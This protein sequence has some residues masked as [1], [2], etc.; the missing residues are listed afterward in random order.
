LVERLCRR[1]WGALSGDLVT[2]KIGTIL[3][4]DSSI[5]SDEIAK[6]IADDT[7]NIITRLISLDYQGYL[8]VFL[9]FVPS[10]VLVDRMQHLIA[11][12]M[13]N[14][15]QNASSPVPPRPTLFMPRPDA[16]PLDGNGLFDLS[17]AHTAFT[18][19]TEVDLHL[20]FLSSFIAQG[21]AE[22]VSSGTITF[23]TVSNRGY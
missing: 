7:F 17:Q 1:F 10:S 5:A 13:T 9:F 15:V 19:E 14:T 4:S 16:L 23:E 18:L 22:N 3:D 11:L 21:R 12:N 8:K 20:L 6:K 2:K